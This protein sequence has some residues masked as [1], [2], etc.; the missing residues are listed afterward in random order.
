M[1]SE[2]GRLERDRCDVLIAT[3]GRL[4]DHIENTGG[5]RNRLSALRVLILDEADQLLDMGF[6]RDIER[7]LAALPRERQTLLFSATMPPEVRSVAGLA[8]K[9]DHAFV[10]TVGE[11]ASHTHEH[12]RQRA[13]VAPMEAQCGVLYALL[14][15][16]QQ[17][18]AEA[19]V[20]VFFC[21]A[22]QTQFHAELFSALGLPTLEIHSRKSQAQRDKASA[23]FR[24]A[25][26]G[27]LFT[28][29]VSARGVDYPDVTAVVQV[30][31][32]ADRSQYIHRL[33]RT[34]RAGKVGE[35]FLVLCP[36]EQYIIKARN[37]AP[38]PRSPPRCRVCPCPLK[39]SLTSLSLSPLT[40]QELRDLP[41]EV[42]DPPVPDRRQLD[43]VSGGLR[44][45]DPKTAEQTYQA[46]LGY[47][48]GSLRKLGWSKE[49]L[50][51][52]ANFFSQVI[53]LPQPPALLK[54]TVG[55]MGLRGVPGLR[56][57]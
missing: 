39:P 22:R 55:M 25:R 33:G 14:R 56:I 50:V 17:A 51:Q 40:P 9:R 49:Q 13:M 5:F 19:K 28:S 38:F 1:N 53:G 15:S 18:D 30:G 36:F 42:V 7:I 32:P 26:S 45:V 41:V 47:Y 37:N 27:F 46:W 23:L 34:A 43:E 11:A 4:T 29:D 2:K 20:I 12:V 57:A 21:T 44:R 52:Q 24:T 16:L 54:K 35:G 6:R 8:L 3:P 31:A 10:D 48:N